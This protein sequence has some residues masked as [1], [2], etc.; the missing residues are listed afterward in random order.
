MCTLTI[1]PD[2]GPPSP[3]ASSYSTQSPSHPSHPT[4]A[5]RWPL[6]PGVLVHVNRTHSLRSGLS[7]RS[8]QALRIHSD[9][10]LSKPF[11]SERCRTDSSVMRTP[12]RPFRRGK[13]P[14]GQRAMSVSGMQDDGMFARANKIRAIFNAQLNKEP[15]TFP[16]ISRGKSGKADNT[17]SLSLQTSTIQTSNYQTV[18][19]D[20]TFNPIFFLD[21]KEKKDSQSLSNYK[22]FSL[23]V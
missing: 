10:S 2:G 14:N 22:P 23:T 4:P 15:D 6:K 13:D 7:S 18:A 17:F 20:V 8:N 1:S 3:T 5:P 9:T 11:T 16:G 21:V 19:R 12:V